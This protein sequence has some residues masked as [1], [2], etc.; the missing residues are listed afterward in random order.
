MKSA[1]WKTAALLPLLLLALGGRA[2]AADVVVL[3]DTPEMAEPYQP[4]APLEEPEVWEEPE[5]W[6]PPQPVSTPAPEK[7]G[8]EK[9]KKPGIADLAARGLACAAALGVSTPKGM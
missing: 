6:I 8:A 3:D 1:F 9:T 7:R 2:F 4:P 5:P